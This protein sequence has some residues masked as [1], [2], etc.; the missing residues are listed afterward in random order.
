MLGL[1]VG[2]AVGVCYMSLLKEKLYIKRKT[3][4]LISSTA[5]KVVKAVI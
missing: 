1:G 2:T 3:M 4:F 5:I